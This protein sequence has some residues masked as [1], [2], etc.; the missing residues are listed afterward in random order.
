MVTNEAKGQPDF[1]T[2]LEEFADPEVQEA[3]IT[4]IRKLPKIKDAVMTAERGIEFVASV[5]S[6]KQSIN[7]LFSRAEKELSHFNVDKDTILSLIALLEKLPKLVPMVSALEKAADFIND[8]AKDKQSQ[9]YLMNGA[10]ELISPVMDRVQNGVSVVQEA[11]ERAAK[12][13]HNVSVLDLLKLLKDPTVQKSLRFI[14]A[15]LQVVAE[16]KK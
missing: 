9:Q 3:I 6:D 10:I 16:R 4:L 13:N 2:C 7:S 8:I 15:I 11:K 5:A 1:N 12:N 14:Q